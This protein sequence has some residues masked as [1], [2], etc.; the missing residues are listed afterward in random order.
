MRMHRDAPT[1]ADLPR[2]ARANTY[3][4]G[5]AA[6]HKIMCDAPRRAQVT[7]LVEAPTVVRGSFEPRFLELPR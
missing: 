2:T 5:P 4:K 3:M 7:N 1:W 6:S